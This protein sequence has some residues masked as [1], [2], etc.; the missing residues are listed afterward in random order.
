[1]KE[2]KKEITTE[3]TVYEITKE[4]L[5]SIKREERTNGRYDVIGY[6]GFSM[7]NY[8]YEINLAGIG[9]F[10]DE[11]VDFLSDRTMTIQNIYGY[12]FRDYINKYR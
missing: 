8:R 4:E 7:K 3:Q 6:I 12:S 5:E 2:I 10:I 1:M 11:L 9:K